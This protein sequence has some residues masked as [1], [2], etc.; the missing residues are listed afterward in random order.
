M[1]TWYMLVKF[2]HVAAASVWLGGVVAMT[3]M[4]GR[5]ARESDP[6]ALRLFSRQSAFLG[7]RVMGPAAAVTLFAGLALM[8]MTGGLT[9]WMAWGLAGVAGSIVLG[10]TLLRQAG[11]ELSALSNETSPDGGRVRVVRRKLAAA[12]AV[13]ILILL[14]TV[15]VMVFKPTL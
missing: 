11:A 2:L 5:M 1:F 7:S 12:G 13:N 9:F 15:G 10:A 6:G 4:N 3:V 8:G 14:S